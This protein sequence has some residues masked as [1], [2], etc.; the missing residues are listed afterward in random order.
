MPTIKQKRA[1]KAVGLNGGNISKAMREVGYSK[2]V[3]KRTDKLTNS[4]GWKELMD[5][6]MPDSI[7]AAKHRQLL[8]KK[9]KDTDEPETQAV[10]KALDM[11]YKLK[12]K[13][14]KSNT[15][16]PVQINF[17]EDREKYSVI[18]EIENI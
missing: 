12:D 13:Y 8:N 7:L 2:Q 3:A 9:D 11:A 1:F 10:S 5:K 18:D 14:P 16:V 4:N 6:H 17:N 15:I